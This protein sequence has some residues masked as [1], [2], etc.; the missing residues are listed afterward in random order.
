MGSILIGRRRARVLFIP[1][2]RM[3]TRKRRWPRCRNRYKRMNTKQNPKSEGRNP[4]EN[5]RPKSEKPTWLGVRIS[6][7]FRPS[8]F[9]LRISPGLARSV[10]GVFAGLVASLLVFE[11]SVRATAFRLPLA[12]NTTTHYYFDHGGVTDWKCGG[13]DYSGHRA[14][15]FF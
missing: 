10:P 1:G 8:D 13:E 14:T 4:K 11:G 5:R 12:A 7:F 6:A 15:H 9:A 2:G 3:A